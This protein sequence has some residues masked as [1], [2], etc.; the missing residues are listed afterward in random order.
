VVGGAGDLVPPDDED[1]SVD[2]DESDSSD[3]S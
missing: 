3:S 1:L 2:V